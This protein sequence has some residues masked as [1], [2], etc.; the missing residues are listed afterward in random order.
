MPNVFSLHEWE[1]SRLLYKCDEYFCQG[2][3]FHAA[4][5]ADR[6]Y[7]L[8]LNSLQIHAR[9]ISALEAGAEKSGSQTLKSVIAHAKRDYAEESE[10][11]NAIFE[12]QKEH[13]LTNA[14]RE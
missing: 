2:D 5:C 13:G 8:L 14:P 3:R 1:I 4:E 9:F 7:A 11:V 12:Y 6:I 10:A